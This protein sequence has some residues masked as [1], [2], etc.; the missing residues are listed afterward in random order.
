MM[1]LYLALAILL[2]VCGT[3][4]MKLSQGFTRIVPSVLLFVF[5][6][7]SMGMLTLA[8]KRID[9][10]LAYAVW[11]GVGTALI[12]TIGVLWFKEP[13]TAL[14]LVSLG[15]IIIG[16]VGLNLSGTVH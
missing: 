16:V 4:C 6:T 8:L 14:K 10:S 11:S 12:A 7:L 15:L 9:V 2:E 3:T 13:I 5:Y 1:W